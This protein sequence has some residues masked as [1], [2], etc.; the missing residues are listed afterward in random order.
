MGLFKFISDRRAFLVSQSHCAPTGTRFTLSSPRHSF[1]T[2]V[3]SGLCCRIAFGIHRMPQMC[4][5][6]CFY[7][8]QKWCE[9]FGERKKKTNEEDIVT[10]FCT[11]RQRHSS[12]PLSILTSIEYGSQIAKRWMQFLCDIRATVLVRLVLLLGGG[13]G[14][15]RFGFGWCSILKAEKLHGH[16]PN[17][18]WKTINRR[19]IVQVFA[20]VPIRT[21]PGAKSGTVR[22][23]ANERAV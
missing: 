11:C 21:C 23:V 18:F 17:R 19:K 6:G 3:K 8:A 5:V 1:S 13:G 14:G 15:V 16:H 2:A 7:C 4:S 20:L 9:T 12:A 10:T 22:S